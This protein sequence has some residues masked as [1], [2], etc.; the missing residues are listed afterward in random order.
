[1]PL[2]QKLFQSVPRLLL[3]F[4]SSPRD[5]VS[6]Y[7]FQRLIARHSLSA[8]L[9]SSA[10]FSRYSAVQISFV[11]NYTSFQP[12]DKSKFGSQ[13]EPQVISTMSVPVHSVI[14]ATNY[15]DPADVPNIDAALIPETDL[16]MSP[17][18]NGTSAT[19]KSQKL[20]SHSFR[21]TPEFL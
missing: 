18:G 20:V 5:I 10:S 15:V 6:R 8:S 16:K 7:H 9:Y 21:L 17:A 3:W 14:H 19:S 12:Q 1:M 4:V 13:E 2:A 11:R